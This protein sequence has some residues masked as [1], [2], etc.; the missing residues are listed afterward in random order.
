MKPIRAATRITLCSLLLIGLAWAVLVTGWIP[1]RR[2]GLPLVRWLPTYTA[3]LVLRIMDVTPV[4]RERERFVDHHGFIFPNH[5]SYLDILIMVSLQPVRFLAKAEIRKW[6]VL[7][8]V[9]AAVGTVF[10]QREDQTSRAA[11]RSALARMKR[12]PPLVIF[13]E[14]AIGPPD[15]IQPFRY[16]AFE[17]AVQGNV[18][19]LPCFIH[20]EEPGIVHWGEESLFQAVWRLAGH[21]GGITATVYPLRTITPTATEDARQL[22]IETHGGMDGLRASLVRADDV[23]VPGL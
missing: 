8:Y 22:A 21:S 4:W 9:A 7:G 17:V 11:A 19:I 6:P 14:G 20:Y 15:R 12:Y 1:W 13:P 10:V 18:P 16:G 2:R 23:V 3:R 5:P